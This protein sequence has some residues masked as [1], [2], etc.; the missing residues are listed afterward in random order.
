MAQRS[1]VRGS[2]S[3]LN[4][5]AAMLKATGVC[6]GLKIISVVETRAGLFKAAAIC[7]AIQESNRLA[8]YMLIE[9]IL[10]HMGQTYS[11]RGCDL[12]FNDIDLPKPDL[13]LGVFTGAS[14]LEKTQRISERFSDVLSQEHPEVVIV[15]G[16]S[17]PVLDC[18]LITKKIGYRSTAGKGSVPALALVQAGPRNFA[19]T[20]SQEVNR[21]AV[22]LLADY[23]FISE[24]KA[25]LNLLHEGVA[26][27][28]LHLV[29]SVNIDTLLRHRARAMHSSIV[30]D[31]QLTSGSDIKPFVLLTLHHL[32]GAEGVAKLHR[33]R[34]AL[35]E[36]AH[37]MPMVFPASPAALRCIHEANLDDYFVDH[38]LDE[39]EPWDAR[40]RI[41][42]IP[43][44]G[45][46][47][48]VKLMAAANIVLTDSEGVQEK[49]R[50][51]GVPCII[52][53]D[54]SS[55]WA[56]PAGMANRLVGTESKRILDAF[57]SEPEERAS[58]SMPRFSDGRAAQRV[59]EILLNDFAPGE[60]VAQSLE[61]VPESLIQGKSRQR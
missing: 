61:A 8:N 45:Y 38:F 34:G 15:T 36:I 58:G 27:E 6:M 52:L 60:Q 28:K 10:V 57:Y 17:D 19:R 51:L 54:G 39:P 2:G 9:H 24:E 20:A 42:L 35:S 22:G 4:N 30:S 11:S 50:V 40:V 41:R 44:L 47:D 55:R 32:S 29:G 18:A 3:S 25:S 31:L 53:A 13:F 37:Q 26:R 1:I 56:T 46:L 33:L 21:V 48:F 16:D 59:I 7:E 14:P 5:D 43:R 23:L 12:Y 49:T